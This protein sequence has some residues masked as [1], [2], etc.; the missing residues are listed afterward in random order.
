[1][2]CP[3]CDDDLV[4]VVATVGAVEQDTPDWTNRRASAV[5]SCACGSWSLYGSLVADKREAD[6]AKWDSQ[7]V[8][9][10]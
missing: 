3:R 2:T 6:A 9:P 8:M 4:V 5:M 7:P 1:M 10:R